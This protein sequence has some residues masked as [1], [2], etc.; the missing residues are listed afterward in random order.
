MNNDDMMDSPEV[1]AASFSRSGAASSALPPVS[2]N[3]DALTRT[4]LSR[5]VNGMA[6]NG[7][8]E[9]AE[10]Y[11]KDVS[12]IAKWL[13]NGQFE[14]L[15]R[16]LAALDLKVVPTTWECVDMAQVQAMLVLSRAHV[17]GITADALVLDTI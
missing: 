6:T 9:V 13:D 1:N 7:R 5:I 17:N 4:N 2:A 16:L 11:G 3:V 15:A 10:I 12:T 14:R 8:K